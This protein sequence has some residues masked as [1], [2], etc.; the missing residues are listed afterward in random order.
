[1]SRKLTLYIVLIVI[2]MGV[3]ILIDASKPKPVDWTPTYALKDKIPLGLY[4]FDQELPHLFPDSKITKFSVTP[5]EYFD[6]QYNYETK[7]YA[8]KG[9]VITID[10]EPNIDKESVDELIYLAEHGNTVFLSMKNFPPH[11][12][13]TLK[14][15]MSSHFYVKDSISLYLTDSRAGNNRYMFNEGLGTFY[16]D[17]VDS[18]NTTVLGYQAAD[19]V[20]HANFIK[21]PFGKGNF[22]LHTQPAVF[23]NF[24]LL[25]GNHHEYTEKLVSHIGGGNLY[26]YCRDLKGGGV[27]QSPLRYILKQPA[28]K[29]ALYFGLIGIFIFMIFNARRRQRIIPEIP[30]VRNTTVDFTK[31]IGNLYYQEGNHHNIIDK[32]IIYL[33]ERIRNEYLI[34]TYSLDDEFI[35]KLHHKTGKPKED[36]RN[37]VK[38]IQVHRRKFDSTEADVIEI[39][40]AIENLML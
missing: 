12:L 19:T 4:V 10:E 36:I 14:I 27:S 25:K 29:W 18:T 33:L 6:G 23:T 30:P 24:H 2:L 26:W 31:T 9:T 32:K 8:V 7:E 21:V 13:D 28:L 15:E 39:N 35:E 3:I 1:M 34:D 40:K 37:L 22:L 20:T 17:E 11:L 16:F 5:Y 38:I